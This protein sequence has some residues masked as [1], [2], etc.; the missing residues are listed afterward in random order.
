MSQPTP[1]PN[2]IQ[3][4]IETNKDMLPTDFQHLLIHR[5]GAQMSYFETKSSRYKKQYE[6]N[7]AIAII[8]SASIPFLV[9]C[10]GQLQF[11]VGSVGADT[12]LKWIIGIAGVIV[13]V[14]E[15]FNALYK[16]QELFLE[17]RRTVE[18]LQQELVLFIASAAPYTDNGAAARTLFIQ[19]TESIVAAQ[20]DQWFKDTGRGSTKLKDVEG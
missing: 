12:I 1:S 6:R 14:L 7:R 9:G 8:L 16:R 18:R 15:G 20:N 3:L 17:Y 5:I 11:N 13:A 10:I 2:L 19:N 4:Y